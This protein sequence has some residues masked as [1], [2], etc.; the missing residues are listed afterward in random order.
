MR[1][2][3]SA[4][5]F[6]VEWRRRSGVRG[7]W[8]SARGVERSSSCAREIEA[9]DRPTFM[10]FLLRWQHVDPRDCLTGE[11]GVAATIQQLA[12]LARPAAG[13]ERDYLPTRIERYDGAWL[14]RLTSG[15]SVAWVAAPRP[16]AK[17]GGRPTLATVRFVERGAEA[18]WLATEDAIPLSDEAIAVRNVLMQRGA[19]FIEMCK[20]GP[21]SVHSPLGCVR[22][23]SRARLLVTNDTVEALRAVMQAKP[24]PLRR[25]D[26]DPTRWLPADYTP[27]AGR[28]VQ[29]R[30]NVTRLPKWRRP[31]IRDRWVM[32]RGLVDGRSSAAQCRA[33]PGGGHTGPADRPAVACTVWSR[34][35]RCWWRRERPPVSWRSHY[36][37]S[38][39]SSIGARCAAATSSR[40]S[41]ARSSHCP[42]LSSVCAKRDRPGSTVRHRR[43][44]R[45]GECLRTSA[46]A[47]RTRR[48]TRWARPSPG[49]GRGGGHT[50]GI[51]CVG[52][53]REGTPATRRVGCR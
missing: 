18:L 7:P 45:P 23:A 41:Q 50:P 16:E 37:G 21:D 39:D 51:G 24:L 9:V 20:R 14:S 34:R 35:S 38:S 46:I 8:S 40:A 29:R 42:T 22:K 6:G 28:I 5:A 15:G 10:A 49:V 47:A 11:T 48:G 25:A 1:A 4:V 17:G 44:E 19:S 3:S 13:W 12:G 2:R 31:I 33:G 43:G 32:S 26:P 36:R 52:G 30:V 27:S 53:R